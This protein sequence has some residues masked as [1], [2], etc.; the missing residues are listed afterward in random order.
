MIL[1]LGFCC[2]RCQWKLMF[3]HQLQQVFPLQRRNGTTLYNHLHVR[4]VSVHV[5]YN[6]DH[7]ITTCLHY[8]SS[9]FVCNAFSA[10]YVLTS[11]ARRLL[12]GRDMKRHSG[13][14]CCSHHKSHS[15][16]ILTLWSSRLI[17]VFVINVSPHFVGE[18]AFTPSLRGHSP[19]INSTALSAL[20]AALTMKRLSFFRAWSQL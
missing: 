5:R 4:C 20:P 3:S 18:G 11:L 12:Y 9:Y 6:H 13:L 17:T 19:S 8:R 16:S 15:S 14:C 2:R 7:V 10:Q 1:Q